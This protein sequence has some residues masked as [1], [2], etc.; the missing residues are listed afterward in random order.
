MKRFL[1]VLVGMVALV[2]SAG[3]RQLGG[4]TPFH[5]PSD[6]PQ[7]LHAFEYRAD[8]QVKADHTYSTTPAFAWSAVKGATSYEL[9]LATS[10]TFSDATTLYTQSSP[11]PVASIQLQLPWMTGNPYALW[12]HVRAVT[13][14]HTTH[15]STPFGFNTAWQQVPN[16]EPAPPGLIRWTPVAGATSYEVWFLNGPDN[17]EFHFTTLNNVADEREYWT[18]HPADAGTIKWRVRA[19]R[20]VSAVSL[21]NGISVVAKGPYSPVFTTRN[22]TTLPATPMAAIAASSNIDST[23]AQPRPLQL[24]PGFSWTGSEDA[25]GNASNVQLS[26]V[27]VF[28]DKQCLNPVMTGSVIGGPAWAPRAATPLLLPATIAD[29]TS[30][31]GGK[32]LGFGAQTATF[33][34]DGGVPVPSETGTAVAAA[35]PAAAPA[36]PAAPAAGST[37]APAA[38]PTPGTANG[39]SLPDNGWPQGRYWWTV[40]PVQAYDNLIT[41]THAQQPGDPLEYHDLQ[42]PQDVC[43]AGQVWPF[44]LQSAPITTT[45]QNPYVSGVVS[46]SR[47]VSA[48]TRRPTFQQLPLI[49]WQPALAAQSY[50]VEVSRHAY[51]WVAVQ[52]QTSVV[53]SAVLQLTNKDMGIWYYRVR[54]VNP[55]LPGPAQKLAWSAPV[56]IRISGD[57]FVV[58]K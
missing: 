35:A 19:V 51:P 31:N 54:G 48:T 30:A 36:A 15:W 32:F 37:P 29:L 33:A 57:T 14:A 13:K 5:A 16:Q 18:Y 17:N 4:P 42:Q 28:S 24:T 26:R 8:E 38:A 25:F 7:G 46:G 58:V 6:A 43:A 2:P 52:K 12:V 34:A 22:N 27:Y 44:G 49:T 10:R 53:T 1:L 55:N 11:T 40:V 56:G 41:S 20:L 47:V 3:A 39:I 45:A 9:E 23:P 21:P 50:E